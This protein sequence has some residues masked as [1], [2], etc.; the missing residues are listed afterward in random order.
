MNPPSDGSQAVRTANQRNRLILLARLIFRPDSLI[1][2]AKSKRQY[3]SRIS[4]LR[5]GWFAAGNQTAEKNSAH[6]TISR[7][8][9]GPLRDSETPP[10]FANPG[11]NIF[12]PAASFGR[13]PS[14]ACARACVKVVPMQKTVLAIKLSY[15]C[16]LLAG[17]GAGRNP[18]PCR[19]AARRWSLSAGAIIRQTSRPDCSAT[20][21]L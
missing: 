7:L 13:R 20:Q 8:L 16:R 19:S 4:A 12:G 17:R 18:A 11:R 2:A 5:P 1:F 3:Y 6:E 9:G 15:Q 21:S 14:R 10:P